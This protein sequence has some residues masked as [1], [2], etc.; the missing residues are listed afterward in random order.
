MMFSAVSLGELSSFKS[1][2]SFSALYCSV[3]EPPLVMAKKGI[4]LSHLV[5]VRIFNIIS[6]EL[7]IA[8]GVMVPLRRTPS[9]SEKI[10]GIAISEL[11]TFFG[12]LIALLFSSLAAFIFF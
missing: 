6:S 1:L 5:V 4:S 8:Y 12:F 10:A 9:M 7:P 3:S 2:F 11:I